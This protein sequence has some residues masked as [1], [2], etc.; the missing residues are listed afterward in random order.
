M[1][2]RY[3]WRGREAR[4]REHER[5]FVLVLVLDS[6]R[7]GQLAALALDCCICGHALLQRSMEPPLSAAV[8]DQIDDRFLRNVAD[9]STL[10]GAVSF[11]DDRWNGLNAI[12]R[13]HLLILV[14]VDSL[15]TYT[16]RPLRL[17]LGDSG[18][19]QLA[20]PTPRCIELDQDQTLG[21]VRVRS[22]PVASGEERKKKQNRETHKWRP[23]VE[24][25]AAR[26]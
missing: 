10:L 23:N 5:S 1:R 21:A 16:E 24:G 19:Q 2:G 26:R 11:D 14:D 13:R 9:N 6:G 4:G 17:D 20:G 3:Q 22:A 7:E 15:H 8:A 18:R 25:S 12:P